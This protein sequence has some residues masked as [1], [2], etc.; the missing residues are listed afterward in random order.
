MS[1]R[2]HINIQLINDYETKNYDHNFFLEDFR[3]KID[4]LEIGS[5]RKLA[6][7]FFPIKKINWIFFTYFL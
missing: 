4:F 2:S 7:T 1:C 3:E 5:F 6:K